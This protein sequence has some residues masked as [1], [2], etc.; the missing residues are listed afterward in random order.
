VPWG[1]KFIENE[2]QTQVHP[3][4]VGP[5]PVAQKCKKQLK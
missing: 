5:S 2:L 3:S 1:F 4:A